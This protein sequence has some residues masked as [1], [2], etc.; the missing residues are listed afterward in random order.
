VGKPKASTKIGRETVG[1]ELVGNELG[2]VK[3]HPEPSQSLAHIPVIGSE[4]IQGQGLSRY[5]LF[6]PVQR[7]ALQCSGIE[8][9]C[10]HLEE[11]PF[12]P[13]E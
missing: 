7:E 8:F 6:R 13:L 10:P 9:G 4:I 3:D 11:L 2:G 5:G 12:P 1:I